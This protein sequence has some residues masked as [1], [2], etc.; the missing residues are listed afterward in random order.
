M[1]LPFTQREPSCA[2]TLSNVDEALVDLPEV[3]ATQAIAQRQVVAAPL[4]SEKRASALVSSR[5]QQARSS[6]V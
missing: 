3:A 1:P 5:N 4:R 2:R 6:R